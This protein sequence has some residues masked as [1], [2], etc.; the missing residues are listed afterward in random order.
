MTT[1]V[2]YLAGGSLL[3]D[4]DHEAMAAGLKTTADTVSHKGVG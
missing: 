1:R 2:P 4:L 3:G